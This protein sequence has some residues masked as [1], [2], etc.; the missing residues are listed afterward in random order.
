[1]LESGCL[2]MLSPRPL[3]T[4]PDS[5]TMDTIVIGDRHLSAEPAFFTPAPNAIA[6]NITT[7]SSS[8]ASRFVER[9]RF[10]LNTRRTKNNNSIQASRKLPQASGFEAAA[11]C[12]GIGEKRKKNP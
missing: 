3:K 9:Y 12:H 4:V 8:L 2:F 7:K 10:Q 6:A 1:M 5:N 11:A